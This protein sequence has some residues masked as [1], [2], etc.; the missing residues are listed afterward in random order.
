MKNNIAVEILLQ[1]QHQIDRSI[2]EYSDAVV[3]AERDLADC[4]ETL[5]KAKTALIDI[6]E[7]VRLL[8]GA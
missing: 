2:S 4:K 5:A 8:Q 1:R 7:A 3:R 6:Q